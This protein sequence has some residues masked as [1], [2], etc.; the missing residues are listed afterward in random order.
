MPAKCKNC[1]KN[2][3]VMQL[4]WQKYIV[5]FNTMSAEGIFPLIYQYSL[6]QAS[7]KPHKSKRVWVP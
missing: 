3:G 1:D 5:N 6:V 4:F 7:G 2:I